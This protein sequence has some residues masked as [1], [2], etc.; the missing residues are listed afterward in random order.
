MQTTSVTL[1]FPG[2]LSASGEPLPQAELSTTTA[3]F[4][5]NW[6]LLLE[7]DFEGAFPRGSCAVYDVSDDGFERTWDD[8]DYRP[9]EGGWAGWPANGGGDGVDPAVSDYLPIWTVGSSVA[10]ST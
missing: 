4:V 8:D 6:D 10:P 5:D 7:E 2:R 9:F 1:R 3:N